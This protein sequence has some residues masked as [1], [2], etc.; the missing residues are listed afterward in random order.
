MCHINVTRVLRRHFQVWNDSIF[1]IFNLNNYIRNILCELMAYT[2]DN[3]TKEVRTAKKSIKKTI[4][5]LSTKIESIEERYA[6]GELDST[7]YK[8]LKTSMKLKKTNYSQK[9]KIHHLVVRTL[10]WPL[11]K[12]LLYPN[13]S[14]RFGLMEI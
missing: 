6:L 7:I 11:I 3:I 10:N 14:R 12:P 9:L 1:W 4:T 13:L 2:Y 5:E 8:S